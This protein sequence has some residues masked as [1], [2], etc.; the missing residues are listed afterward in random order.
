LGLLFLFFI[1]SLMFLFFS[2]IN[3]LFVLYSKYYW[4]QY[5][6]KCMNFSLRFYFE[7]VCF[8]LFFYFVNILTA[9]LITPFNLKSWHT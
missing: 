8:Y 4:K 9:W 1:M 5:I 6:K 7:Y 2:G 3:R